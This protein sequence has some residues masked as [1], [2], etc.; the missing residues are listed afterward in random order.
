MPTYQ[1]FCKKCDHRFDDLCK[2]DDVAKM[3]CPKCKKKV[4]R[5]M[6]A[7]GVNFANPRDSSKWHTSFDIRAG[8]LLESAKA[9][10]RAAEKKSHMG[11]N[12]YTTIDDISKGEGI[13]DAR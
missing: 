3:K 11:A 12:P 8:N 7:P 9:E 4:K 6:T 13:R 10:R 5:E 2:F 1:F